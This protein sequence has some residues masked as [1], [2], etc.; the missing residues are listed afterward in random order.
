MGLYRN[1]SAWVYIVG[2]RK[3][4]ITVVHAHRE[5]GAWRQSELSWKGHCIVG[6]KQGGGIHARYRD[7]PLSYPAGGGFTRGPR[8][9]SA[10][11]RAHPWIECGIHPHAHSLRPTRPV[12]CCSRP[13]AFH[14]TGS[15][16]VANWARGT[17]TRPV[18]RCVD[19]TPS[20]CMM[21]N[22]RP[23]W[24]SRAAAGRG[25][26]TGGRSGERAGMG[27]AA[28]V[29]FPIPRAW[30]KRSAAFCAGGA[31]S[32]ERV[33]ACQAEATERTRG[34]A[35]PPSPA[36]HRRS[37]PP[38]LGNSVR[39]RGGRV[40][41]RPDRRLERGGRGG[42]G[43]GGR[44]AG[45]PFKITQFLGVRWLSSILRSQ[46]PELRAWPGVL[47]GPS[48]HRPHP[49]PRHTRTARLPTLVSC[50]RRRGR[51]RVPCRRHSDRHF[52]HSLPPRLSPRPPPATT[53]AEMGRMDGMAGMMGM[54][55][56]MFQNM[57]VDMR[58][59]QLF[60]SLMGMMPGMMDMRVRERQTLWRVQPPWPCCVVDDLGCA[61]LD[62]LF[63]LTARRWEAARM[64]C[65]G[66]GPTARR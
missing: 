14:H 31:A 21:P 61:G 26:R 29:V 3:W 40:P 50:R 57:P 41:S 36:R 32:R 2:F 37:A 65:R 62:A 64:P 60:E 4:P 16:T 13:A 28:Y 66:V 20:R 54:S 35:P 45:C 44:A 10:D 58:T 34:C 30:G 25:D 55:V 24:H 15:A 59:R 17:A 9:A 52:R 51:H 22:Q 18:S 23:G 42:A 5:G 33:D 46:T 6:S 56:E 8:R 43:A 63:V 12:P 48:G 39:R 47:P 19:G 27:A 1:R 7:E 38:L 53:M 49:N 11:V